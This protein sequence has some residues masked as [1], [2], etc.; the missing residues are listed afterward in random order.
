MLKRNGGSVYWRRMAAS[1]AWLRILSLPRLG[2]VLG[3]LYGKGL[4]WWIFGQGHREVMESR[5]MA[6][7]WNWS[8]GKEVEDDNE[9]LLLV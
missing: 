6:V 4:K 5:R 8:N 2:M 3:T 7:V 9:S 1:Y